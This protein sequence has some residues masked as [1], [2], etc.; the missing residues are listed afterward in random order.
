MGTSRGARMDNMSSTISLQ[1]PYIL[2]SRNQNG[3][4]SRHSDF[5]S[6]RYPFPKSKIEDFL[7]QEANRIITILTNI[8]STTTPSLQAGD[9]IRNGLL[10]LATLLKRVENITDNQTI[11]PREDHTSI[12][13]LETPTQDPVPAPMFTKSTQDLAPASMFTKLSKVPT[14]APTFTQQ[15]KQQFT[16]NNPI[17]PHGG[18]IGRLRGWNNILH[19]R[20]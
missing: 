19:L 12:P 3:T 10:Q 13:K 18:V 9:P 7:R 2:L 16:N 4:T 1:M 8:P 6:N 15:N 20:G 14:L 17:S 11:K 5:L